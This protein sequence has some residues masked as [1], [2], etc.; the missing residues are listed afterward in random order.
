MAIVSWVML[1]LRWYMGIVKHFIEVLFGIKI[2]RFMAGLLRQTVRFMK[3]SL[4]TF[5]LVLVVF[6]FLYPSGH[7]VSKQ[8]SFSKNNHNGYYSFYGEPTSTLFLCNEFKLIS[9]LK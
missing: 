9:D 1:F 6:Y 5:H 3:F 4:I 8:L 7:G 2:Y